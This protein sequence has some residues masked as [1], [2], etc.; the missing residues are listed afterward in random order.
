MGGLAH[1]RIFEVGQNAGE[2]VGIDR[3]RSRQ[4]GNSQHV[5]GRKIAV[6][7]L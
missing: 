5:A 4:Q 6:P 7:A 1:D 3:T 2:E